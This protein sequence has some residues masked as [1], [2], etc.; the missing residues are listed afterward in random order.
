MKQV[1][2][3]VLLFSSFAIAGGNR[4]PAEYNVTVHVIASHM[5]FDHGFYQYAS[6][7]I[8][9]KTYELRS[10]LNE[11]GLLMSGDY[12]ARLVDDQHKPP[13]DVWQMYEFLF[14]DNKTRR[15]IVMEIKP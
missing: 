13:Y 12:K 1:A 8:D 5:V 3:A 6:A 15:F 11:H 14:S 4:N 9:G 2:F 10:N 7:S